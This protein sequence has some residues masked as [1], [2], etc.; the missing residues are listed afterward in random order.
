VASGAN[1][2]VTGE[3]ASA[4]LASVA[5]DS[6]LLLQGELPASVVEAVAA[7][8]RERGLRF[9]LNLAPVSTR[10]AVVLATANPLIVNE[11]E[12]A[13]LVGTDVAE[14]H[15]ALRD[16]YGVDVV[17]TVGA[18]GALVA[19]ASGT[20]RQPSPV[21]SAVVDTTGAGDAFV[22]V[23]AAALCAGLDLERAVGRGVVA[24]SHSVSGTGTVTSYADAD[25][26]AGLEAP[27]PV[28]F[29]V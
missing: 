11:T 16:R 15:I 7:I 19:T 8:A 9:V 14:P 20:W 5:D 4:A 25:L 18:R 6:I 21:P 29:G 17:V 28:D 3:A 12:A 10:D 24:A 22:G 13:D 2:L 27:E 23:L 26:L 1:A